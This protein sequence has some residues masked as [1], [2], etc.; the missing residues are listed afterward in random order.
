MLL[1]FRIG[2]QLISNKFIFKNIIQ[3]K[4][5]SL[6]QIKLGR[7]G[8]EGKRERERERDGGWEKN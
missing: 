8:R 6:E 7:K 4:A 5:C 1:Y 3:L 2:Q